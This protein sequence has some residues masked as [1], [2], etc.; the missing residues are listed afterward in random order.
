MQ[1][2]NSCVKSSARCMAVSTR[3]AWHVKANLPS[4]SN[5]AAVSIRN[6]NMTNF[7]V[8][9]VEGKRTDGLMS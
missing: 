8:K 6:R 9:S 7:I 2:L 1:C 4:L 5:F 3:P